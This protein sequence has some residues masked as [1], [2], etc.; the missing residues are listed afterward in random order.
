[1]DTRAGNEAFRRL[2]LFLF[3]TFNAWKVLWY[4]LMVPVD[5]HKDNLQFVWPSIVCSIQNASF[6]ADDCVCG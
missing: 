2:S 6:I 4:Q 5:A 3:Q 1:Y